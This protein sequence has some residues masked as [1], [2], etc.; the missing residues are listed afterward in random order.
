MEVGIGTHDE[1][2]ILHALED[3]QRLGA[4]AYEFQMIMG[5]QA[6]L[7]R[8]LLSAGHP[9]RVTVH[10]GED[11]H[12]WSIRRLKENPEVARYALHGRREKVAAR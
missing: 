5:V 7:R 2:L 8:P 10:F 1:Y 4:H 3:I 12:P 9:V 11:L 6:G